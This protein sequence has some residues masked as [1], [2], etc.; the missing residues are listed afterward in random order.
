MILNCRLCESKYPISSKLDENELTDILGARIWATNTPKSDTARL[1][2][3]LTKTSD[4][5]LLVNYGNFLTSTRVRQFLCHKKDS[6]CK[7]TNSSVLQDST[8]YDQYSWFWQVCNEFGYFQ[9]ADPVSKI[10]G[11]S[12]GLI[13]WLNVCK[14]VFPSAG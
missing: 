13:S 6:C 2:D 14:S 3:S 9:I 10:V 8:I 1:C 7:P 12:D 5:D 4:P 11:R